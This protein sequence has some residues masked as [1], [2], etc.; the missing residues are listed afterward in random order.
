MGTPVK[1]KQSINISTTKPPL[2]KDICKR[3]YQQF[4]QLKAL[5]YFGSEVFIF[6]IANEQYTN[7]GYTRNLNSMGL[8]AGVA[9]YCVLMPL[10]MV[11]FIEFKRSPRCKQSP[12][13]VAFQ[14][15]CER[16]DIPYLLTSDG[17]QAVEWIKGLIS[18]K[19]HNR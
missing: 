8:T 10:R 7:I 16:L 12:A 3:F 15:V 17:A 1:S 4:Q 13:Q 19:G 18:E 11:A 5:N 9:D 2:E 6:H 14:Q